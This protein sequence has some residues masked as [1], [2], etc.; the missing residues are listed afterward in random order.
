MEW[1]R[2]DQNKLKIMLSRE[3][4][5]KYALCPE[6][7]S[8]GD[9]VTR[10]AFREI[11]S[12]ATEDVSID[13]SEER[14]YIQLFPSK[15]GGCELFVTKMG[16]REQ[17][18]KK[19]NEPLTPKPSFA[20]SRRICFCFWRQRDLLSSCRQLLRRDFLGDSQAW[21]DDMGR[22]WLFLSDNGSP[23]LAREEFSFLLEYGQMECA[24]DA[25]LFLLEHGKSLCQRDA[26][27]TLGML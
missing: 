4:A 25:S 22:F 21:R 12:A 5:T 3:D 13:F 15:E 11:L 23:L 7:A 26:V 6:T 9:A 17:E 19:Q 10:R 2:I 18:L 16:T 27:R 24:A 20:A 14:V 8:I 1:I